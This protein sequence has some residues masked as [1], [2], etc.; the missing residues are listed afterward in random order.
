VIPAIL[1]FDSK[2]EILFPVLSDGMDFRTRIGE[3]NELQAARDIV[4]RG[5]SITTDV[6]R[7]AQFY[8]LF[9]CIENF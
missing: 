1:A 2:S 8:C 4:L 3:E 7:A 9:E 5:S 6:A